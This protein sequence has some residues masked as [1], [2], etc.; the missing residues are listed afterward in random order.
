[1][2]RITHLLAV[3]ATILP[4]PAFAWGFEGHQVVADIARG[5]LAPAVRAKVDAL[6]ASDTDP[7]TGHDMASEATWAD[8]Y[9]GHGHRETAQW[10]FVDTELDHPD[11]D[12]AC[13][14]HPAP[15][16]PASAGPAQDCV[17]DKVQEFSAELAAPGTAPAERL[18][19]LKYLLHFVGDMHQP[20]H[21]SDNHDRGGNCVLLSLGGSRTQNL[22]AYWDTAVVEAFGTDPAQVAATL[23]ARITPALRQQ[24]QQ[25][26]PTSWA[27]E[28]FQ[29]ARSTAYTIGSPAGC[30]QDAT[31]VA[32]PAGYAEQAQAAA[33]VQLERAGVRLA[34]VL[35]KALA[36]VTISPGSF[37]PSAPAAPAAIRPASVPGERSAASLACSAEA[38]TKNLHGKERQR[39]RRAC[40]RQ[41]Q[42]S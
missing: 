22:H 35:D 23:R 32:L 6:L 18:L 29:V 20:L 36:T 39:F 26:T 15:D 17:V 34:A 41:Q 30:P 2:K 21:A 40:I 12:A 5:E 19:A 14:G 31:P 13:F 33:A 4:L 10:H 24:W 38:D 7:L 1:M 42:A 8:V 9:R 16:Q 27:Q 3:A 25:G 37:A 11:L 28:A